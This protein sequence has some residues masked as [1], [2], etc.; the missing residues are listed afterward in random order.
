MK[1]Y[2]VRPGN[3]FVLADKK[4]KAGEQF[5]AEDKDVAWALRQRAVEEVPVQ[6]TSVQTSINTPPSAG[7]QNSAPA[8]EVVNPA[9]PK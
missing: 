6:S 2:K 1:T 7:V 8:K 4:Y 5:T 3:E 9:E